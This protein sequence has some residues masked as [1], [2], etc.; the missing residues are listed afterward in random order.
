MDSQSNSKTQYQSVGYMS[1]IHPKVDLQ[2]A[3]PLVIN[4]TEV[5][6]EPSNFDPEL[7]KALLG[8]VDWGVSSICTIARQ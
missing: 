1:Y 6:I 5:R 4:A 3:Y 2:M 7:V 8:R